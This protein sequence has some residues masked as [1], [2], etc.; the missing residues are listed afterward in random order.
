MR[1]GVGAVMVVAALIA[2]ASVLAPGD[3]WA[4][5]RRALVIGNAAY[6]PPLRNPGSDARLMR[7]TLERLGFEVDEVRDA[8]GAQLRQRV[9]D[10]AARLADGD[11]ATVFYS[12]HGL[13]V[14]GSN[15]LIGVDRTV[16]NEDDLVQRAS[17]SMESVLAAVTARHVTALL[18]FDACRNRRAESEA[19]SVGLARLRAPND[20]LIAFSTE[21]GNTASDG[22]GANSPFTTALAQYLP[23]PNTDVRELLQLVRQQ[24][25]ASTARRQTPWENI[26]LTRRVELATTRNALPAQACSLTG[27]IRSASGGAEARVTFIN[28]TRAAVQYRY[29]DARGEARATTTVSASSQRVQPT[30]AGQ[31]WRVEDAEGRCRGLYLATPDDSV[32]TVDE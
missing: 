26:S 19:V 11:L 6:D 22:T 3:A 25:L 12:G 10:F 9:A 2:V 1:G 16:T 5:R 15:Y 20:A 7:E 32:V 17:V 21:P 30:R 24:V 31:V 8:T 13:A 14:R 4:Q 27:T 29:I 18:F 23:R 28:R